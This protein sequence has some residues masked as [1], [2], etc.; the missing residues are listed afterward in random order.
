MQKTGR[1]V[2]K[3]AAVMLG[4]LSLTTSPACTASRATSVKIDFVTLAHEN[5]LDISLTASL[6]SQEIEP[7]D[8]SPSPSA[9]PSER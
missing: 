2:S 3:V 5:E 6:N 4:C 9:S 1:T 8:S 7:S